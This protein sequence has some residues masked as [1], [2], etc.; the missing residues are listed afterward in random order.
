MPTDQDIEERYALCD[1]PGAPSKLPPELL[2]RAQGCLLGQLVGDSLGSLVEFRRGQDIR[3][4]YP[5]GVRDLADGG[6]WGTLAGQPTDDSEMALMLARSILRAGRFDP[7]EA[8]V[9][10]AHWFGS[11]P[12]D[13]G[14]TTAQ[15]LGPAS[16]A[17]R[18]GKGAGAVA[19]AAIDAA[20]QDSQ[21]NGALMRVSPL[22]IFAHGLSAD[23][24]A[25][26][27]RQD[28]ALTHPHSTCGDAGAVF[29]VAIAHAV[30]TGNGARDTYDFVREWAG[31]VAGVGDASAPVGPA[32]LECLDLAASSP[33][34]DFQSKMGWVLIALQNAFW[35]LLHALSLEEGVCDT[36]LRGGDTDTNGAIAGALLGAVHGV[37]AVPDRWRRA[38]LSCRPEEGLP[39]VRRPR[40][41]PLWPIDVLEVA[42]LLAE[43]GA[44]S[45]ADA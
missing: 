13:Y 14:N 4:E 21:A 41:A 36:V 22:G 35:Q 12:F 45:R 39:G 17:L 44:G 19:A 8:A 34:L 37:G 33:P 3:V 27:V 6:T 30:A 20:N 2:H 40:P 28:A 16:V 23:E 26:L 24:C 29:A 38:V 42:R 11:A 5:D 1:D 9:A 25:R 31:G 10:Y 43:K 15:A 32:V 18:G 7:G